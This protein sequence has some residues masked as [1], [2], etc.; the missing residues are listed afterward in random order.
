MTLWRN[1]RKATNGGNFL[2]KCN[3]VCHKCSIYC[4]KCG[5][6]FCGFIT[7]NMYIRTQWWNN[8]RPASRVASLLGWCQT[9]RTMNL[10]SRGHTHKSARNLVGPKSILAYSKASKTGWEFAKAIPNESKMI[11]R[12]QWL[13]QIESKTKEAT[14]THASTICA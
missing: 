8:E 3:K 4:S 9:N 5:T 13:Q 11:T 1:K 7:L 2:A 12:I 10:S 14:K 6:I